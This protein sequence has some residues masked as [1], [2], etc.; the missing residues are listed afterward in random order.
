MD[1]KRLFGKKVNR[2]SFESI[3]Q[4]QIGN[5]N[6]NINSN[7]PLIETYKKYPLYGQELGRLAQ[8]IESFFPDSFVIDIGANI[9]DTC[10]IVRNHSSLPL[11][12]VEGDQYIYKILESNI[13][14]IKNVSIYSFFLGETTGKIRAALSKQG[15]NT[16]I[17]PTQNG[18]IEIDIFRFDQ[19][20]TFQNLSSIIKLIKVDCEGFDFSIVRGSRIILEKDKPVIYFEYNRENLDVIGEDA[21]KFISFLKSLGYRYLLYYDN[22]GRLML[23]LSIDQINIIKSLNE[24]IKNSPIYYYDVMAFHESDYDMMN[25][26]FEKELA[27][28][29]D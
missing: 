27:F 7:N 18:N 23:P 14:D 2:K 11:I 12:A 17:V 6:L 25:S 1:I 22:F 28:I 9:G 4:I 3:Q 29:H 8:T 24:Y 26:F 10:A 20:P 21:I 15:W 16:T 19:I 5:I 13:N